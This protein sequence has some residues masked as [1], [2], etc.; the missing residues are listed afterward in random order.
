MEMQAKE[1]MLQRVEQVHS[2]I[3]AR[4]YLLPCACDVACIAGSTARTI[5]LSLLLCNCCYHT[6]VTHHC[7]TAAT[8]AATTDC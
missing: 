4:S 2:P 3:V 8:A 6:L 5:T 7:Y 1:D